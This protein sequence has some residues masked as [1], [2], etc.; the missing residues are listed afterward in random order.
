MAFVVKDRV[1]VKTLTTG[2][3][4]VALGAAVVDPI[5]GYY[6]TFPTAGV[7]NADTVPY[8]IEDGANWEIGVGT[9]VSSGTQLQRTTVLSNSAGTTSP[10]SLSG[11]A[12]VAIV[13]TE[14]LF[15]LLLRSD[16][17]NQ[18][19]VGGFTA[20]AVNDGTKSSGTYTPSSSG[21]NFRKIT[22][23]GAF[24][25]AA[26]TAT[27]SYNLTIDITNGAS[28]GA[29]TFSGFVSGYPKGDSYTTGNGHK[30]KL[31]ISKTDV[32]VTA[33]LEALQ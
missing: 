6:R 3:G 28:A 9:Y 30:F 14:Q 26:P 1:R 5:R 29:I 18:A 21:G 20:T 17:A 31:H 19:L 13:L 15:N 4:A 32:G 25:L 24:S 10:I 12:E 33:T 16:L 7:A 27:G 8:V 2:T 23:N 11:A 22:A